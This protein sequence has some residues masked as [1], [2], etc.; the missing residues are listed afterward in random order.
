MA[1]CHYEVNPLYDHL[2]FA[3]ED[4]SVVKREVSAKY[5]IEKWLNSLAPGK[6]A[7]KNYRK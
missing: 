2:E 1:S 7:K 6:Q 3:L 5:R 4:G